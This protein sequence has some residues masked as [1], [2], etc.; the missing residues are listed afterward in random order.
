MASCTPYG[1]Q[2]QR[3]PQ[4]VKLM[5]SDAKFADA[6]SKGFRDGS[7]WCPEDLKQEYANEPDLKATLELMKAMIDE[8]PRIL[9]NA[10]LCHIHHRALTTPSEYIYLAAHPVLWSK[11]SISNTFDRCLYQAA[12]SYYS[13]HSRQ[14]RRY[15]STMSTPS[16]VCVFYNDHFVVAQHSQWDGYPEGQGMDILH[17]LLNSD[18]IERLKNGLKHIITLSAEIV[19]HI[20][21]LN[22]EMLQHL[23]GNDQLNI[24]DAQP[25]N[26]CCSV[27]ECARCEIT[28]F[29]PSLSPD[30]GAGILEIIAQATAQKHVPVILDLDFANDRLLCEWSYVVDLDSS[31]LEVYRGAE[32]KEDTASKRFTSIGGEN[33]TVPALAKSFPFTELPETKHD[34]IDGLCKAAVC[35]EQDWVEQDDIEDDDIEDDDIEDYDIENDDIE[36]DDIEDDDIENNDIGDGEIE[37]GDIEDDDIEDGDIEQDWVMPTLFSELVRF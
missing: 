14:A 7:H 31:V 32:S 20:T 10:T 22:H 1:P 26:L 29:W 17:F 25:N 19:E 30:T 12:Y 2:S 36:G 13:T 23:K 11:A 21:T 3:P 15:N 4:L 8:Y 27:S 34:F 35:V 37:D 9:G 28:R 33:D 24:Q 16:L 6:V 5:L 18:N